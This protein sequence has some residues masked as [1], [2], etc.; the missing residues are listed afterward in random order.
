MRIVL[1]LLLPVLGFAQTPVVTAFPS[2]RVPASSRGLA[3][4]DCGIASA[5]ENQQL[6]YNAAK[7][8]F[9]QNFHQASFTYTPWAA[10]VSGDTKMMSVAYLGNVFNTSALGVMVN[11]LDL[12]TIT[13]RDNNGASVAQYR[14]RDYNIGVSYALQLNERHAIGVG[15]RLLG[16][17]VFADAPKS[18]LSFC[19]DISYYGFSEV[20]D[21]GRLQ[22]GAVVSNI[23]P[24]QDLQ[25]GSAKTFLPTNLSVGVSYIR[26][27]ES[28]SEFTF[29]L[30]ANKLLV[31]SAVN[32]DK[33]ILDG[34]F[35]SFGEPDGFR[36]VRISLGAEY[37]IAESF[38]LRCG[39][40]LENKNYGNRK[41]V[42]FGVGYKGFVL[43]QSFGLNFHYL[44]PFGSLVPVSPFQNS[45]GFTLQVNFGN[46]Q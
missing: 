17:N 4:G 11:Y 31:P 7:S 37:G 2:L 10:A 1:F 27:D 29:A 24:K 16:Q 21:G 25:N 44:V 28:G 38:Y 26:R 9:I 36:K 32:S 33:G 42:G 35:A 18:V 8:A 43:D 40:S 12:G 20:G 30:D 34:M 46:F 19:G 41:Y 45:F 14:A 15:L 6:Y 3:M 23:G 39:A 22:W 5:V 13:T